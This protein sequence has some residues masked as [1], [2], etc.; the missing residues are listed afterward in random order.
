MRHFPGVNWHF[1]SVD[2]HSNR[3]NRLFMDVSLQSK[4]QIDANEMPIKFY[5]MQYS[6]KLTPTMWSK[7]KGKEGIQ[8]GHI[9]DRGGGGIWFESIFVNVVYSLP[10]TSFIHRKRSA[11]V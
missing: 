11:R 3:V 7:I 8:K 1:I 6:Q 4:H 10:L 2:W 5:K 9:L